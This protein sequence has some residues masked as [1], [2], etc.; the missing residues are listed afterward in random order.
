MAAS[1]HLGF[2]ETGNS[3]IR[4]RPR[5]TLPRTKHE[6]DRMTRC[7][8]MV[9]RSFPKCEVGR[10]SVVG[11]SV[12]PQ[13]IHCSHALLFATLGTQRA[14]SNNKCKTETDS[15]NIIRTYYSLDD[16]TPIPP[17]FWVF[18]LD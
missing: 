7:R 16:P 8:D 3:A 5:K 2:G 11:R 18:P 15:K 14:R 6:V 10:G 13:Y 9:V 12:G 4:F 17:E 1:R